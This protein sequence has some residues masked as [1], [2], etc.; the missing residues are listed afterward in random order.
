MAT[1]GFSNIIYQDLS[2]AENK[3]LYYWVKYYFLSL[4]TK[5]NDTSVC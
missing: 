1:L 5:T 2:N 3:Y 4:L